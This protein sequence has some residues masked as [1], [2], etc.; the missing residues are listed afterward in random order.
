MLRTLIEQ[1]SRNLL[2]N[3][4]QKNSNDLTAATVQ[5]VNA[6]LANAGELAIHPQFRGHRNH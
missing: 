6:K 4:Q 3:C 2:N 5:V 1:H